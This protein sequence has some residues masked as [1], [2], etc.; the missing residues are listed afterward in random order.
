MNDAMIREQGRFT[1]LRIHFLVVLGY[2][3][4]SIILTWPLVLH[5]H[6]GVINKDPVI[7]TDGGFADASQNTWNMWWVRYALEHRQNPFWSDKL[8]YPEGVQMYLQTMNIPDA[9]FTL[10]VNYLAGPIA[11]YNMAVIMAFTLTGYAGF[12]LVRAFVPGWFVPFFC[13]VLLTASP[14]HLLKF[15]VNQMPL[16]SMQWL[17]FYMYA[18][19]HL[20]REPGWRAIL[21]AVVTFVI[22]A[23]TSWY[24][25]LVCG[26]YTIVWWSISLIRSS[27]RGVLLRRYTLV[28]FGIFTAFTPLLI[29]VFRIRQQLPSPDVANDEIWQIYIQGFSADVLG[30]F[31]P[32]FSHPLWGPTAK[33]VF[34]SVSPVAADGWYI[35][36]GWVLLFCAAIGVWYSWRTHWQLLLVGSVVWVLALGPSLRIAGIDTH[37]PLPYAVLQHLPVLST[38]RKPSHFAVV[39]IVLATV[40]AGIG[41]HRLL[42]RHPPHRRIFLLSGIVFL[43]I[44]ELYPP[45]PVG[46]FTFDSPDFVTQIRT[47]PG[48]V[49]DL[50]LE[51]QETS[52]SLRHQMVHE[53]PIMG[54]YVA[55]WPM[56]ESFNV[57]LLNRI[58]RMR[59]IPDIVPLNQEA[60]AAMQCYSPIRHVVV[61]KDVDALV[62]Q[63]R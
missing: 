8:Y 45:A 18:L 48:A 37:L 7:F 54:G 44:V 4:V 3:L 25:A 2:L 12:L 50:P 40:F 31:F 56:Y 58:G 23:L 42:Q 38:A 11:A 19:L 22:A 33:Q 60:F 62:L 20:N 10:P 26:M 53:Q 35:A 49:A 36:A 24:W 29:G 15:Q 21:G 17:P 55:R 59:D 61:R 39:C 47:R 13:G 34:G 30:L 9:I 1:L 27:E 57:P 41:V 16:I 32:S 52:R 43:A 14:F 6:K 28:S 63:R 46:I 51:R 5:F